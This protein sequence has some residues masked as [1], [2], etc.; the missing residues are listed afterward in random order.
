MKV[1][2]NREILRAL[3][4]AEMLAW[5]KAAPTT[6]EQESLI[7][8]EMEQS[9]KTGRTLFL[10]IGIV[11]AAAVGEALWKLTSF[12]NHWPSFGDLISRI[13]AGQ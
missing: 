7:R 9:Q 1:R 6:V 4:Q 10:I 11:G 12:L 8:R 5:E 3:R 2:Q 13:I